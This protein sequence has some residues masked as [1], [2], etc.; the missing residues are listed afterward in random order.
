MALDI[1]RIIDRTILS[2]D[3]RAALE[4]SADGWSGDQIAETLEMSPATV[5]RRLAS[6]FGKLANSVREIVSK[7][8]FLK[9]L[10]ELTRTH[11]E[12]AAAV[13]LHYA[14]PEFNTT[15][16][17]SGLEPIA[18]PG[19]YQAASLRA[20][21]LYKELASQAQDHPVCQMILK[22][23]VEPWGARLWQALDGDK[24]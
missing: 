18:W 17:E 24:S 11:K 16:R 5:T 21:E 13:F 6:A 10:R 4:L 8:E 22:H 19:K 20:A 12:R 15:L 23:A 14:L 7:D 1:Q 2:R 9:L 3:E